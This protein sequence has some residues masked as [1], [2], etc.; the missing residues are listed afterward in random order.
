MSK[1]KVTA[2]QGSIEIKSDQLTRIIDIFGGIIIAEL[3]VIIMIL[4]FK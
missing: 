2:S 1:K 3:F 4:V